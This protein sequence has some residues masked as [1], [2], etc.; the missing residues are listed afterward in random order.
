MSKKIKRAL[1]SIYSELQQAYSRAGEVKASGKRHLGTY[2]R[3]V[4][5][6]KSNFGYTI[7]YDYLLEQ[8]YF[9]E[10]D[11][12][13]WVY[14]E[15]GLTSLAEACERMVLATQ[16]ALG[17]E[18]VQ[19]LPEDKIEPETLKSNVAY[20]QMTHVYPSQKLPNSIQNVE[21]STNEGKAAFDL[22]SAVDTMAYE[23]HTNVNNFY[24][25]EKLTDESVDKDAPEMAKLSLRRVYLTVEGPFPSKTRRQ[26][27]VV[28]N[29]I[30]LNPLELACDSL[31]QK[32][33]QI[34]RILAAAGIAPRCAF[35]GVEAAAIARLDFKGL[36]LFL[37]GAVSPTVNV[38]VLAYAEA[39]TSPSQKER[40]GQNGIDKLVTSFKILMTELQDALEVNAKAIRSD[41]HEY[42]EMLQKS[43]IGMLERLKDF[44]GDQEFIN[45]SDS[46]M[47]NT[48]DAAYVLNSIGGFDI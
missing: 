9:R 16:Q 33:L 47:D 37:Q 34:R 14:R 44:F 30:V 31:R 20:I 8:I 46:S 5:Y 12:S 29:E 17:H 27:V 1:V 21:N 38:G 15:H 18:R 39:F 4:F 11:K 19:C 36:Q 41:Q 7:H 42:Q 48:Y 13:E 3:V 35:V 23:L 26:K 2:F 10:E 40:Y 24:Y 22:K 45:R 43:F 6:G 25:E 32:A 28:R